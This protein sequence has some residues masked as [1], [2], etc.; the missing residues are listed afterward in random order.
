M[1]QYVHIS[2]SLIAIDSV[3]YSMKAIWKVCEAKY[4]RKSTCK[5]LIQQIEINRLGDGCFVY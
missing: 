1:D 3:I 5:D 2:Q 4:L